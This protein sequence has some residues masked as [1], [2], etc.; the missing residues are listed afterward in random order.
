MTGGQRKSRFMGLIASVMAVMD[1]PSASDT[2]IR[3]QLDFLRRHA[4]FDR[5]EPDALRFLGERTFERLG[6]SKTLMS[7][8]RIICATNKNL[9]ELVR[10]GTFRE[11]LYYRLAVV[12]IHLPPLRERI[13]DIPLLANYFLKQFAEEDGKPVK[14]FSTDAMDVMLR[15]RWPGNVRELINRIHS[16][17]IMS[18]SKLLTASDLGFEAFALE[19]Q[20]VTL[21]AARASFERDIL[22]TSLRA[23]GNNVSKTARQLGISRITL[24]RAI[25][26]FNIEL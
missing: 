16:G 14:S 15:H 9:E 19:P 1:T 2:L 11:D 12:P 22:E 25:S 3:T 5:M 18:D 13:S 20:T 21:E 4:P 6:S 24:Y 23:N 17:V 7:D 8:V 26:K 10:K